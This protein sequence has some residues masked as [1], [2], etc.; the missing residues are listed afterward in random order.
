MIRNLLSVILLLVLLPSAAL[1]QN[2]PYQQAVR[3]LTEADNEWQ[4]TNVEGAAELMRQAAQEIR[5]LSQDLQ[6]PPAERKRL[7]RMAEELL[8]LSVRMRSQSANPK[9]Q[10]HLDSLAETRRFFPKL[11]TTYLET[12]LIERGGGG[13]ARAPGNPPLMLSSVDDIAELGDRMAVIPNFREVP[14]IAEN[15]YFGTKSKDHI[16]ESAGGGV[17]LFDYDNDGWLDIYVVN[18]MEI[19]PK[20]QLVPHRNILYRNSGS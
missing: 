15:T 6:I 8:Q 14:V 17:A 7:V 5:R 12:T 19:T 1:P 4:R 18:A 16:L 11:R 20:R 10:M 13:H 9:L 3:L 2:A